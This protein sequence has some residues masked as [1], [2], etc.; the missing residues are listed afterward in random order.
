MPNTPVSQPEPS[1]SR[2]YMPEYGIPAEE[3]GM[4]PWSHVLER[5]TAARN[6]WV[7]TVKPD[8][9]PHATPVWGVSKSFPV[10]SS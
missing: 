3:E 1:R 10:R 5:I 9:S 2:P 4:L 7:S 6:Y 8:G